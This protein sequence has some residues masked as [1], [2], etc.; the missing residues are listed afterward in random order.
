MVAS[1]YKILLEQTADGQSSAT[2]LEL[3]D[4]HVI[5]ITPQAA[6]SQVQARLTQ[7]LATAQIVSIQIPAPQ[8]QNPWIEFAGIFKDDPDFADIA[9][10][11]RAERN[12]TESET[13][14]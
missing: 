1:T 6:I 11:I 14:S 7:R 4:C 2:V 5:A 9:Q 3:P 10:V 12:S 8:P 13:L